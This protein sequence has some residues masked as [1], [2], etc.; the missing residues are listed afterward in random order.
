MITITEEKISDAVILRLCGR[1]DSTSAQTAQDHF[2][3]VIQRG[4]RHLVLDCERLDYISS[5]GLRSFLIAAKHLKPAGG[6]IVLCHTNDYVREIID[7]AGFNHF[8]GVCI[9][10][11]EALGSFRAAA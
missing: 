11:D 6:R 4:E 1:L 2:V 8:M 7:L 10:R 3:G 9:T 5:A